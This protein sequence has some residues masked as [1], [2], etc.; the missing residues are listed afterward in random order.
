MA[1]ENEEPLRGWKAIGKHM[2]CSVK[3]AQR[4]ELKGMP[5]HRHEVLG[6]IA[7][8]SE[9]DA[10]RKTIEEQVPIPSAPSSVAVS[11][12]SPRGAARRR[13]KLWVVGGVVCMLGIILLVARF[14]PAPPPLLPEPQKLAVLEF[15]NR[16]SR[17]DARWLSTFLAE[18][19]SAELGTTHALVPVAAEVVARMEREL[20]L[21]DVAS[22]SADTLRRIRRNTG[23]DWVAVGTYSL[24]EAPESQIRLQVAVQDTR[25]GETRVSDV[26][27]GTESTLSELVAR[28][29]ALLRTKLGLAEPSGAQ[30]LASRLVVPKTLDAQRLYAE[31]IRELRLMNAK[32]AEEFLQKAVREEPAFALAHTRLAEAWRSLGYGAKATEEARLAY[33]LSGPLGPE[34]A[35]IIE[36]TYRELT[37]NWDRALEVARRLWDF[38]PAN[39]EYALRLAQVQIGAGKGNDALTTLAKAEKAL[40]ASDRSRIELTR[41]LAAESIGDFKMERTAAQRAASDAS[42]Q[43]APLVRAEALMRQAWAS[44][45]MA[46]YDAAFQLAQQAQSTFSAMKERAGEAQAFKTMADVVDDQGKH[47]DGKKLYESALSLFRE[48]GDQTGVAV[49]LNSLA[50]AYKDLG[51][52]AGAKKLFEESVAVCRQTS[53][54]GREAYALNGVGIVLWR[55]GDLVSAQQFFEQSLGIFHDRADRAHEATLLNNLAII[56]EHQGHLE[57]A[58]A[59]YQESLNLAK[60]VGDQSGIARNL[61]NLGEVLAKKGEL[62]SAKARL[63]EQLALGKTIREP[64]QE[65]YA[66]HGLGELA[67]AEGQLDAARKYLKEAVSLRNQKGEK[68]LAAE[69]QLVLA[70]VAFQN[71]QP[72]EAFQIAQSIAGEFEREKETDFAAQAYIVMVEAQTAQGKPE[73]AM[74]AYERAEFFGAQS[75][76]FAVRIELRLAKARLDAATGNRVAAMKELERVRAEADSR[77]FLQYSLEARLALAEFARNSHAENYTTDATALQR[78]A[79]AKGFGL[80]ARRAASTK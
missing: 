76:D 24:T 54:R 26:E 19:Y 52:L 14:W 18:L 77:G 11:S 9:L 78:E 36:A 10:W 22:F 48:I 80:I 21:P 51:D 46:D 29:T 58:Y 72:A 35:F 32:A 4:H 53:N 56:A 55:Q 27:V 16:S 43:E 63:N 69:S 7:Y 40:P 23:A 60:N 44:Y 33:E 34:D 17:Q 67:L 3:T 61:G 39:A 41:A 37:K 71:G 25:S 64:R 79:T 2:H 45:S 31:G 75:S 20:S 15:R 30:L 42:A 28:S 70:K 62:A 8:R 13:K 49:T 66:L 6:V 38:A 12:G 57:A 73:A 65:A 1:L 50:Y 59:R 47:E 74:G 68:G 5:V